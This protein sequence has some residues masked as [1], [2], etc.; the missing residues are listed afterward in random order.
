MY[1]LFVLLCCSVNDNSYVVVG[2]AVNMSARLMGR[3]SPGEVL[4][5]S[6]TAD[7]FLHSYATAAVQGINLTLGGSRE[8]DVKGGGSVKV[9]PVK[10]VRLNANGGDVGYYCRHDAAGFTPHGPA[11]SLSL[12]DKERLSLPALYGRRAEL[13]TVV[14]ALYLSLIHI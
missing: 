13:Q 4:C 8:V 7:R 9:F 3:A 2:H 12:D 6:P 5:D 11:R 14:T 1:H 10:Q